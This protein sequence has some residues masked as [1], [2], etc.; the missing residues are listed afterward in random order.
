MF[1][2]L[3]QSYFFPEIPETQRAILENMRTKLFSNVSPEEETGPDGVLMVD[4]SAL[5]DSFDKVSA[6]TVPHEGASQETLAL[7]TPEKCSV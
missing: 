7:E 5:N 6:T 4:R 3:L 1:G 2:S